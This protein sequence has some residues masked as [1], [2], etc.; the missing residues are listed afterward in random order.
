M[1][2]YTRLKAQAVETGPTTR[3]EVAWL[4]VLEQLIFSAEAEARWLDHCEARLVRLADSLNEGED[5]GGGKGERSASVTSKRPA[6][7]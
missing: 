2:D 5:E 6:R 3:D 4:L 1:Q 7:R